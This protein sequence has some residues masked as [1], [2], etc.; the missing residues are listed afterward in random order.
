MNLKEF[1][2]LADENIN[3]EIVSFLR[4][5]GFGVFSILEDKGFGRSDIDLLN[6]AFS[7]NQVVITQDSDFGTLVFRDKVDFIGI[8][9]L[10]PCHFTSEFHISTFKTILSGDL[11]LSPP[12]IVVAEN[13]GETVKIRLRSFG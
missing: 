7:N 9:Y 8:V 13:T 10:R 12:F 1:S 6:Q 11:N 5:E 4:K 3:L 2:L